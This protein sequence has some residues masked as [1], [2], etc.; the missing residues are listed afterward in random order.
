VRESLGNVDHAVVLGRKFG[1]GPLRE[2]RGL[3]TEIYNNVVNSAP[4]APNQLDLF[5]GN[6][7]KVHAPKRTLFLVE[8]DIALHP[9]GIQPENLALALAPASRKKATLVFQ[10]LQ[11]DNVST[12]QVC[13]YEFQAKRL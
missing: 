11:F 3:T 2:S 8:R 7:L 9:V 13:L 5:E 1:T 4:A 12:L 10:L 6:T